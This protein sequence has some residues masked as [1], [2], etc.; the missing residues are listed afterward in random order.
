MSAIEQWIRQLI[1]QVRS[2]LG[3]Q[4]P[5]LVR[6]G[7]TPGSITRSPQKAVL[8]T[9]ETPLAEGQ[10]ASADSGEELLPAVPSFNVDS[11]VQL[12]TSLDARERVLLQSLAN[13]IAAGRLELPQLPATSMALISLSGR[14]D[15]EV[16]Q[17]VELIST[18]PSLAGELLRLANSVIY[19]AHVPAETLNTAVMRVGM[20]G[21]RALVFSVS[22]RGSVLRTKSLEVFTEEVWRQAFSVATI[23]REIAPIFRM[24]KERAFLVG[25]LHDVGKIAL[26]SMMSKEMAKD[27]TISPAM[28][29]R[30]FH[31][32]HQRAG[33]ALAE[34]WRLNAEIVSVAGNHHQYRTNEEFGRSAALA[35]LAHT[36]DLFLS[37]NDDA[38][39][40][41]LLET[42]EFDFLEVTP[43]HREAVLDT[44][45]RIYQRSA[46]KKDKVGEI[47]A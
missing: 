46:G 42:P 10:E 37:F 34:N 15:A 20:T 6:G 22:V 39:Y 11:K 4:R 17:V 29:G 27:D 30:V 41:G 26:L 14:A 28:V 21:L 19:A 5:N 38:A 43:E 23:A 31:V 35:S 18:D 45:R 40:R 12:R 9:R 36:L 47:A 24:D 1:E 25:L 16:S 44:A 33:R 2:A 3:M 13:K 7:T 32:H 8:R